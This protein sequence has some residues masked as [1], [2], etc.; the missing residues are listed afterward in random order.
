MVRLSTGSGSKQDYAT[1]PDFIA[2]VERTFGPIIFDLAAHK[3]NTK[4]ERFFAHPDHA[5]GAYGI[6]ALKQ[7]WAHT[8]KHLI[9][10][11]SPTGYHL[12]WLNPEFSHITPWAKKCAQE[13]LLLP[14]DISI[15][16]LVPAAIGSN[17]F[18]DH[19]YRK[20]WTLA[21]NG[22]IC[23]DG[24]G[25]YPKDCILALFGNQSHKQLTNSPL[26]HF[27]IWDW[28]NDKLVV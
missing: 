21:V 14:D 25:L 6:D 12:M 24:V 23:F 1:P 3:D 19:V 15:P 13:R 18:R 16:L 2:A 26:N 11:V 22:R 7:D 9:R 4:H 28:R 17:W 8:A 27:N 5:E 20:A 10:G